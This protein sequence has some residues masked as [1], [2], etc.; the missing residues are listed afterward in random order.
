MME[1]GCIDTDQK[2]QA[3]PCIHGNVTRIHLK[4]STSNGAFCKCDE[5]AYGEY[6]EHILPMNQPSMSN[7]VMIGVL[8]IFLGVTFSFIFYHMKIKSKDSKYSIGNGQ[9]IEENGDSE[10]CYFKLQ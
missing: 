5:H 4:G 8:G 9:Y 2:W 6:C 7:D 1:G 10:F 3:L